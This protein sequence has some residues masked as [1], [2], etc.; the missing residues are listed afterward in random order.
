MT[1]EIQPRVLCQKLAWIYLGIR[2]RCWTWICLPKAILF[3]ADKG[4]P[5]WRAACPGSS[6]GRPRPRPE[7]SRSKTWTWGSAAPGS[8][9]R[10]ALSL[11]AGAPHALTC[12][13]EDC[14]AGFL[15]HQANPLLWL[16]LLRDRKTVFITW[17][18]AGSIVDTDA[19]KWNWASQLCP[20]WHV[21]W[22]SLTQSCRIT[23][24][25]S[26]AL[27]AARRLTVSQVSPPWLHPQ[28]VAVTDISR[29]GQMSFM[30]QDHLWLRT[31]GIE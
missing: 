14:I 20:N 3:L 6:G 30:G 16:E 10:P 1:L 9:P 27:C 17:K 22:A 28:L 8:P 31:T 5:W 19:Q 13:S 29:C 2:N 21:G 25:A 12:S 23:S 24:R 7:H 4:T 18:C 26:P 15:G 11:P